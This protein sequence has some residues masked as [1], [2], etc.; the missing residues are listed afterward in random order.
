MD[1]F[2]SKVDKSGGPDACWPWT[3]AKLTKRG[4]YGAF[5]L[6]NKTIRAHRLAWELTNGP[7]PVGDGWHGTVVRHL[8][9]NAVCCN[10]A[11]LT[12]GTTQ[13]NTD[14]KVRAGR[15]PRGE[16]NASAILVP[17]L[18]RR[19][20]ELRKQGWLQKE[21]AAVVGCGRENVSAILRRKSWKHL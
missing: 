4:G 17:D 7:I 19:V 1:R 20:F 13:E 18:V 21:I 15:Q 2:W 14:D 3:G 5:N 6:D 16:E 9:H 8:C 12:I 11:H 10:P